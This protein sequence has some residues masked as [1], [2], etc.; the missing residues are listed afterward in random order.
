MTARLLDRAL[1]KQPTAGY[2]ASIAILQAEFQVRSLHAAAMLGHHPTPLRRGVALTLH[3]QRGLLLNQ[4]LKAAARAALGSDIVELKATRN[5]RAPARAKLRAVEPEAEP[6]LLR[7]QR[8]RWNALAAGLRDF[9]GAPSTEYY[10]RCEIALMQHAFGS[11]RGKRLLKLDLWNEA[12][13]TRILHWARN[14]GAEAFGIDASSV[15]S[16]R[17]IDNAALEGGLNLVQGD[18]RHLPF[19]SESFDCLYTMG[20]IEHIDE[21]AQAVSEIARVLRPGGTAVIGVPHLWDLGGR[22]LLVALLE[23]F[24]AYPYSPEKS[25]SAREL[26]EVIER[27]GLLAVERTGILTL[28]GIVR[29]ADLYCHTRSLPT[30]A[31]MSKVVAPF[32]WL[33]T[34][35]RWPGRFGYLLT[36][37]A[38]KP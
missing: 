27:A 18:I 19:A 13:N 7:A 22:P 26:R 5:R 23:A 37:I 30:A 32:E 17:A 8:A 31:L 35:Y 25:F 16:R 28:P 21:H 29:M 3:G 11:L 6:G 38:R 33:E 2:T 1:R 10:R 9:R 36:Y 4:Q 14:Q 24:D 12:F 34:R 20:T 15:V